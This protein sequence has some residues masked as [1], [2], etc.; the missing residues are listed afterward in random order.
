MRKSLQNQYLVTGAGVNRNI[1]AITSYNC[2]SFGDDKLN[3]IRKLM[4]Y[5]TFVLLQE[6]WQYERQFIEKVN[7]NILNVDCIV[8]SPMDENIPRVG[9]GK[10][11]V[12]ILWNNNFNGKIK[13]IQCNSKR[14][15]AIEVT[16][17]NL[18]FILVN[19]YM[20]TDPG[21]GNYDILDFKEVLNEITIILLNAGTDNFILGGDWNSDISRDTVQSKAFLSFIREQSLSLC[22]NNNIA[23]VPFTFHNDNSRSILDHFVVNRELFTSMLKYESLFLVDDFSDHT[24]LKLDLSVNVY[25]NEKVSR[26]HISSTAWHKCS[27]VLKQEYVD[28]LDNLL[29]QINIQHEA[30]T[31]DAVNCTQHNDF[32]NNMYCD[33]IKFCSVADDI[34]P[35]TKS[36]VNKNDPVAGWNDYVSDHRKNALFWHQYW[37]DQGRPPQGLIA[38]IRRR[39]RAK[40]HYA[41]RFV[42]KEKNR[43]ISAK[44][45]EA[46]AN[47][48]D[49]DLWQE[50]K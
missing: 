49:R 17:E 37:L 19:V 24:P 50:T 10:G 26:T 5:S 22:L 11:G 35:K 4:K 15:C 21:L 41:V 28:L 8:S 47:N 18:K 45:A 43:I 27:N 46:I 48:K 29:L 39:T 25:Y 13:K 9:R 38:L 1:L 40:Y 2:K 34:L 44:M 6:H 14:L 23:N 20:P 3:V 7:A 31:C 30:I 36:N 16:L 12:A 42:N 33:I 32:I